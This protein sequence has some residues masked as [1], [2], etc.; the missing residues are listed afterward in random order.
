[1]CN[2]VTDAE[3]AAELFRAFYEELD[4]NSDIEDGG[5]GDEQAAH[6]LPQDEQEA[7]AVL[8]DLEAQATVMHQLEKLHKDGVADDCMEAEAESAAQ[9]TTLVQ[10]GGVD[11]AKLAEE[12][13]AA[14]NELWED[15]GLGPSLRDQCL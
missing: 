3:A 12:A 13:Q 1:M 11:L 9:G 7:L 6:D 14:W 5:D 15:I 8:K 2:P 4:D 10:A